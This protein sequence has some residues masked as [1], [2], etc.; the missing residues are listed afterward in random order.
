MQN[1]PTCHP[2]FVAF[3]KMQGIYRIFLDNAS[4]CT[5]T[6]VIINCKRAFIWSGTPQGHYYWK[7][8]MA[9]QDDTI[10][11]DKL[12][13]C[14]QFDIEDE[15]STF[16]ISHNLY[17]AYIANVIIESRDNRDKGNIKVVDIRS[18]FS[19]GDSTEGYN[20]WEMVHRKWESTKD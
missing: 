13:G 8:I 17:F 11:I 4:K 7:R 12:R 16:L 20:F 1:I 2:L 3:L 9:L 18:G 5:D 14:T 15:L 6:R 10:R 19:W